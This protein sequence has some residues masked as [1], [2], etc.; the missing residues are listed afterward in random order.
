MTCEV[1]KNYTCVL[2]P[3]EVEA[4]LEKMTPTYRAICEGLL[5]THMRVEE[6]WWFVE[7][8][9]AYKPRRRCISLPR[10]A[11]RKTETQFKERDV[12]LSVKGCQ[13]VEHLISLKLVRKKDFM[14]RQAMGQ[15]LDRIAVEAGI[16]DKGICPKMF[17][18]TMISWLV[19]IYPEKHAWINSSAGHT[20][21]IQLQHYTGIAFSRADMEDMRSILKGWGDA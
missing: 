18:K 9:D 5:H 17:R 14:S 20:A 8:P 19:A 12:V 10:D 21:T 7:N 11:I 15:Y 6:F 3:H 16:G 1:F 2:V 13:V 4:M